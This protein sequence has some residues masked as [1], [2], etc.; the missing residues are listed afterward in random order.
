[1]GFSIQLV[2]LIE[3]LPSH[4]LG[5]CIFVYPHVIYRSLRYMV[6]IKKPKVVCSPSDKVPHHALI[7]CV[8]IWHSLTACTCPNQIQIGETFP[9]QT[10]FQWG[11]SLL[12]PDPCPPLLSSPYS[13]IHKFHEPVAMKN[14]F[15][16]S[17]PCKIV[18]TVK[19]NC[20]GMLDDDG[21]VTSIDCQWW[22]NHHINF[23][24]WSSLQRKMIQWLYGDVI[25]EYGLNKIR[26]PLGVWYHIR[27]IECI[28][29]R[30]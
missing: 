20:L 3:V 2:A 5:F 11:G 10:P 28:G 16:L 21:L 12:D 14:C 29:R 4:T 17:T 18:A 19:R 23:S 25:G 8:T 6:C 13:S 27:I 9:A 26:S 22:C 1:M 15:E 30:I 24:L 7:C